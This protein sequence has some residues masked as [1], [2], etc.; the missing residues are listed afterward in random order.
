MKPG[1]KPEGNLDSYSFPAEID[2]ANSDKAPP[3]S[4]DENLLTGKTAGEGNAWDWA[5]AVSGSV[6]KEGTVCR[7]LRK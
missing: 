1:G 7:I 3:Q 6:Q 2:I 4:V 5:P